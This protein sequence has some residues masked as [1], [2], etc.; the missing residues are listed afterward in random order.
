MAIVSFENRA[1]K[2]T[3][4]PDAVPALAC[5]LVFKVSKGCITAY[6]VERATAPEIRLSKEGHL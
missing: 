1:F 4:L 6:E 2:L 3:P 5:I